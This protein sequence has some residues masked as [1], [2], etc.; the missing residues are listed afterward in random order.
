M[1]ASVNFAGGYGPARAQVVEDAPVRH[2]NV[3]L[4]KSKVLTF[5][6]PFATAVIGSP[7]IADLVPM[8][9]HTLYVQGKKVGTTN[10]SVFDNDKHLVAVVDLDVAPDTATLRS[11][12]VATTGATNISVTS[13]NGQVIL[14]GEATD[15]VSATRAV[16][17]AR[18]LSGAQGGGQSGGQAGGQPGGQAGAQV[19]V[20]DALKVAPSQQVMLKVRFLE[21]DRTAQRDLGVNWFGGNKN[22]IGVSGLGAT[23]NSTAAGATT[24]TTTVNGVSSTAS[25]QAQS[26]GTTQNSSNGQITLVPLLSGLFP[27]GAAASQP[28]GALLAQVVNT[29]GVKIDTLISALEEEGLVK[30]LAEPNLISQSGQRAQFFA[31]AQIP[32]PTVQPGSV[33]GTT[34]TV[35]V[36]YYPCGVTLGFEPTVLNTGL[37]NLHLTPQV[38]Q[39]ATTT[40]VV[41]NGTTIPELTTRSA[42]TDVELRD[43]QSFAIAGLLQAQDVNDLSQLPWLGNVPVLGALFRSTNYQ[44][45]ETDLVVIVSVRLVRPAAP[46]THLATPFDTTLPANDVDLFLMGDLERKKKY[47][48]FVT[49]GGGLQ[50]PYGHILEAH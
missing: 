49:S 47:T 46:G 40:P 19:P 11:K 25:L 4:Y 15:A 5:K 27:G 24:A 7:D 22:G 44:K 1:A 14:G 23:A 6:Q 26:I 39:V 18:G 48:E 17:L 34:P 13:A 28:F 37:I 41:V 12:I 21:V 29:N 9:D 43:G 30:T 16:D 2:I 38:C 50:G 33:A 20:I 32:I 3:T 35:T 36:N 10:V 31:G 42:D 45:S 8:T